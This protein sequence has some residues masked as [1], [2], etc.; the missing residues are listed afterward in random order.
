MFLQLTRKKLLICI[1][2]K[3]KEAFFFHSGLQTSAIPEQ[4]LDTYLRKHFSSNLALACPK[5]VIM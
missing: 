4:Y 3:G 5:K 1:T 2:D